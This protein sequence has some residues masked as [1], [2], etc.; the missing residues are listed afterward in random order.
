MSTEVLLLVTLVVVMTNL[1]TLVMVIFYNWKRTD[2]RKEM[3][4]SGIGGMQERLD[5]K[6]DAE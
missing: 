2:S 5:D 6:E 3:W 1:A 4:S